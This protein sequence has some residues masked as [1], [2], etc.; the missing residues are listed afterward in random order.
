M[1]HFVYF[2]FQS[3]VTSCLM[4]FWWLK[5]L[6][7][8][9]RPR[10]L[11]K[12]V[13]CGPINHFSHP[14]RTKAHRNFSRIVATL[15]WLFR[16]AWKFYLPGYIQ[17]IVWSKTRISKHFILCFFFFFFNSCFLF[18]HSVSLTVHWSVL[19]LIDT[20][21]CQRKWYTDQAEISFFFLFLFFFHC[22]S[23]GR[24][25]WPSCCQSDQQI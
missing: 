7:V 16:L 20:K 17:W 21:R 8:V 22:L 19:L 18:D 10:V 3:S 25:S 13:F 24:T 14:K 6:S 2:A 1:S 11:L 5:S 4:K 12:W 15:P 9:L 23:K